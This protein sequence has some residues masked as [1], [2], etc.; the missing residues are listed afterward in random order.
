MTPPTDVRRVRVLE[1]IDGPYVG[2]VFQVPDGAASVEVR[3]RYDFEDRPLERYRVTVIARDVVL[4]H[5]PPPNPAD[6]WT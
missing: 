4:R 1:A 5:V 3:P 2:Y 6:P